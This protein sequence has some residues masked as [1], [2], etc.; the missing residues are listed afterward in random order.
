[1]KKGDSGL[2]GWEFNRPVVTVSLKEMVKMAKKKS[3]TLDLARL[4]A[5]KKSKQVIAADPYTGGD[6]DGGYDTTSWK[7]KYEKEDEEPAE[8]PKKSDAWI[9]MMKLA[10]RQAKKHAIRK[11]KKRK[12]RKPKEVTPTPPPVDPITPGKRRFNFDLKS[13]TSNSQPTS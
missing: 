10:K 13:D 9:E 4:V 8:W 3:V 7:Y 12:P 11:P 2:G 6:Y 5:S 1:V